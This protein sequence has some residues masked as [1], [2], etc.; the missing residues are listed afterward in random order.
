M[1]EIIDFISARFLP[2]KTRIIK[3]NA[4]NLFEMLYRLQIVY[5]NVLHP[6]LI[7]VTYLNYL[8]YNI[9]NAVLYLYFVELVDKYDQILKIILRHFYDLVIL[10]L[11]DF[12]LHDF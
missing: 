3:L 9:Q 7:L 5:I 12:A 1:K 2:M 10:Y 6:V 8:V 4:Q 11:L